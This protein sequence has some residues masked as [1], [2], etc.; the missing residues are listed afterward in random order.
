MADV[1][2]PRYNTAF[3]MGIFLASAV[4]NISTGFAL[5]SFN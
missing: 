1:Q 3:L 5:A 2:K 4:S